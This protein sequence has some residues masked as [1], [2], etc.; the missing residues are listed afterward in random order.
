MILILF[1]LELLTD[2]VTLRGGMRLVVSQRKERTMRAATW[3]GL[4]A[5]LLAAYPFVV[6]AQEK[7]KEG[8]FDAAKMVGT[9]TYASG[10]VKG[11]KLDKDHFKG[12]KVV[13]TR[14][15]IT[16]EGEQ[17]KFVIKYTLDTKKKPVGLAMEMTESPFGAGATAKGIV[18]FKGDELKICYT[19]EGDAPTAFE[20][21]DGGNN[22]LF[23]LQRAG[24]EKKKEGLSAAPA[25][26][27]K[28]REGIEHGKVETV[29]Y[30]SKSV[31]G[32][33]KMTVYLPPGYSKD[34]KYPVFYLL[35]GA[36]DDETGW[37]KKGTADVI[38]DNLYAEKKIAPMIVV[39]PNGFAVRSQGA[40][41]AHF[42]AQ[43]ADANKDGKVTQEEMLAAA[44][45]LFHEADKDNKGAVDETQMAEAINR[46]MPAPA[47]GR[48][49]APRGMM[50]NN[51]FEDDLLKDAIPYI[52]SH[53]PVQADREHR[54]IAGLSMGGG[55][56]L[57][58]GLKHLDTFAYVGG[59]SSALGNRGNT[60]SADTGKQLRLLWLSCGDADRLMDA[61]KAFHTALEERKIPHVWHI[62]SGGHTWPVWKNDLYLLTPMLFQ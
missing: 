61:S 6:D 57:S 2:V 21:K 27:D 54:A 33:R 62:D 39:M 11:L 49:G 26:F 4:G 7:K 15:K 22:H 38:L 14:D 23:V 48:A 40:V 41:F 3:L 50:G 13:I 24:G 12:S 30:A 53:Y 17:G 43:H 58:I 19:A 44:K 35:H 46:L 60:V 52:E 45:Q 59:F 20:A 37:Q 9:W 56:A 29:E 36:G 51:A 25:G 8:G 32:K 55:Q 18:E 34:R 31:G 10:G 47:A 5:L 28:A 1:S 16:L 42:L